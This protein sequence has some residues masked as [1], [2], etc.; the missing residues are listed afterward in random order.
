MQHTATVDDGVIRFV[1]DHF[2]ADL[3]DELAFV[4]VPGDLVD[5]GNLYSGWKDEF[6]DE[7]QNLSTSRAEPMESPSRRATARR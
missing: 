4:M 2:G 7:V 5:N 3:A 1:N 6:F